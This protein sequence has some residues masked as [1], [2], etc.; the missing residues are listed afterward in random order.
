MTGVPGRLLKE[1]ARLP[2]LAPP[3]AY[4]G[5]LGMPGLTAYVGLLDYTRRFNDAPMALR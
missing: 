4:L 3:R 5:V 1:P 2:T